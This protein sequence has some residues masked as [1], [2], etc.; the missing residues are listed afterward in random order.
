MSNSTHRDRSTSV[1]RCFMCGVGGMGTLTTAALVAKSSLNTGR[2]VTAAEVHGMSQRGGSVETSV[3]AGPARSPLIE[4]GRADVFL[5]LEPL[6]AIRHRAK[7]GPD[8]IAVINTEQIVPVTVTMGG[9]D[10]P[11]QNK[12]KAALNQRG[13]RVVWLPATELADEQGDE[14]AANSC[15]LGAAWQLGALPFGRQ[16]FE[17]A[18]ESTVP[19]DALKVNRRAFDAG[20]RAVDTADNPL[21]FDFAVQS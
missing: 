13:E 12:L 10:Y 17:Q 8:T 9:P 5:G 3:I 1:T 19:R 2:Q 20:R 16:A 18:L 21:R 14:R 11:D 15:M 6:E 7:I 4:D